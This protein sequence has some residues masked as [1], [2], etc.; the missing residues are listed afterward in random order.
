MAAYCRVHDY[1]CVCHCEPGGKLWQP[2]AGFMTMHVHV[3]VS[4]VESYGSLL[5][6]S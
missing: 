1:A 3:T 5:V 4:L 6:G 2:T